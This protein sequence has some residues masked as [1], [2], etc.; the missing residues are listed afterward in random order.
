MTVYSK[1][2]T[3]NLPL[4]A[5]LS[6]RNQPK[7]STAVAERSIAPKTALADSSI[8]LRELE[9]KIIKP[10]P[11][12]PKIVSSAHGQIQHILL[13]YPS[14]ASGEYSYKQVYE[15]LFRQLPQTTF[16]ILSHPS[17]TSDLQAALD[18]A[19]ASSRSTIV[20]AP[21]YL[22]FLVWA[23][24]PYVVVH[25]IA[26]DPSTIFLVEPQV[27]NR[28]G[29]AAIAELFAEATNIQSIQSPLYF[30]GGN[31]LIGDDFVFIGA[32]YPKKTKDLIEDNVNILLPENTE[33]DAFIKHLYSQTFDP[34]RQIIYIGTELP[35]PQYQQRPITINKEQW[36]E[37]IYLGTGDKQPIF[38]I[39]MF[40]SLAGRNAEGKYRLLVGSPTVADKILGRE[41]IKHATAEIFD[42]V[43]KSLQNMGFEVI[44]NPLPITYVDNS[45]DKIR[46]WYFA[47]ANNCLVQI[48]S[49]DGNH[50]WLPTYGY[51]DWEELAAIDAE[52][53]RIW[54]KLGF[55]VHQLADFHPFAQNL[56][57][58]HCIKKYL[59][60]G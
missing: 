1:I 60:R 33:V 53:K 14:Y 30:Q 42:D 13:C 55:V 43:A 51:G 26:T 37:E 16:T 23:E 19:D 36:V 6:R 21:E 20:E 9:A 11:G 27:F 48:D 8:T 49:C 45:T 31:I 2:R 59:E 22:N 7:L 17:V 56:G 34:K 41:P 50:V 40:I 15:D 39:D 12:E 32:D 5:S 24:D 47:T 57:S 54:E 52:N 25:D 35:V 46:T 44:R 58:V 4:P 38:H 18:A 28:R 3:N 10:G 29:D